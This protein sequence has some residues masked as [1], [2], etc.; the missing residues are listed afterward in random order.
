[1]YWLIRRETVVQTPAQTS[2][3]KIKYYVC[4]SKLVRSNAQKFEHLLLFYN[5]FV[6]REQFVYAC[7]YICNLPFKSLFFFFVIASCISIAIVILSIIVWL[8]LQ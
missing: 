6:L 1:M 3:T 4:E 2:R 8:H 5:I 7:T